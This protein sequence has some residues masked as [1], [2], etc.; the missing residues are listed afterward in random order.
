MDYIGTFQTFFYGSPFTLFIL[1]FQWE[2][3]LRRLI[4]KYY[5]KNLTKEKP[6]GNVSDMLINIY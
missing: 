6:N 1:N 2:K 3:N 5:K 4:K